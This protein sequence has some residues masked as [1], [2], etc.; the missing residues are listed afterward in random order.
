MKRIA[1]EA[2]SDTDTARDY[3]YTDWQEVEAFA[4]EFDAFVEGSL[5]VTPPGS[6]VVAL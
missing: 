5:G 4:A 6:G 3:E 2:T 1:T